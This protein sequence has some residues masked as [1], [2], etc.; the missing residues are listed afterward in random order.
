MGGLPS[1]IARNRETTTN[2]AAARVKSVTGLVTLS[3]VGIAGVARGGLP[4]ETTEV[5]GIILFV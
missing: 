5:R 1:L 4:S 2:P 3:I